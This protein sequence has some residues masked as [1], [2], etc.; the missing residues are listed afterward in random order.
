M[1]QVALSWVLR[2]PVRRRTNMGATEP[3]HLADA[4]AATAR[5]S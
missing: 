3:H 1:G 4:V 2:K 5:S